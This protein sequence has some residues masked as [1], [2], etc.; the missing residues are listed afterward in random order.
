MDSDR[1]VFMSNGKI[2]EMGKPKEL[3]MKSGMFAEMVQK[4]EP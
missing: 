1:I 2:K 3:L 4:L